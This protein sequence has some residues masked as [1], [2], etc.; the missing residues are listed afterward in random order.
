MCFPSARSAIGEDRNVE[1]AK[2]MLDGGCDFRIENFL[3][4]RF[5]AVDATEGESKVFGCVLRVRNLDQGGGGGGGGAGGGD[6]DV[7]GKFVRLGGPDAGD[8]TNRHFGSSRL[9]S[10]VSQ[11]GVKADQT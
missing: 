2:Q 4:R 10:S 1:P 9:L 11:A 8:D 6:D 5:R 7:F 3:L